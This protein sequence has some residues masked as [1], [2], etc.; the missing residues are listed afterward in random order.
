MMNLT[1]ILPGVLVMLD[2]LGLLGKLGVLT[3]AL[4]STPFPSK[5]WWMTKDGSLNLAPSVNDFFLLKRF[6]METLRTLITLGVK[7]DSMAAFRC[8][9]LGLR[10]SKWSGSSSTFLLAGKRGDWK[11]GVWA[12][13]DEKS[14]RVSLEAE[15]W[16]A[17]VVDRMAFWI[18]LKAVNT[19]ESDP[20]RRFF[21]CWDFMRRAL[22]PPA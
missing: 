1:R 2:N 4:E 7:A 14:L 18:P 8:L 15:R 20:L 17:G 13:D 12:A 5:R 6:L 22:G 10:P 9:E 11:I 19:R 21:F 3:T 16:P